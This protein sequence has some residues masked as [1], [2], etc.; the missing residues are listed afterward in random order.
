MQPSLSA[1]RLAAV[2]GLMGAIGACGKQTVDGPDL[3]S[4]PPTRAMEPTP[5]SVPASTGAIA[6]L[7]GPQW[8][9]ERYAIDDPVP[10]DV[11]ITLAVNVDQLSG[12]A[13][14]N[15]Y[16]GSVS[17]G[18]GP[19]KLVIGPLALTEMACVP[20]AAAAETRYMAALQR[21][22]AFS[23]RGRRLTL[24]YADGDTTRALIYTR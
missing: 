16:M 18:D 8:K 14:C 1:A 9:L 17:N 5:E 23:V 19:G 7:M 2:F 13:G 21:A 6:D 22:N 10:A 12:H 4:T 3:A 20:P 24:T 11:N 15:R